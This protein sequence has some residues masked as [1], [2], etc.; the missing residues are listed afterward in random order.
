MTRRDAL[1]TL[2][3]AGSALLVN[4][5]T[6]AKGEDK[7]SLT[8][9]GI[10]T[11]AFGIHQKNQWNGRH[12]GLSPALAL[13]EESHRVGAA[14]IQVDLTVEDAPHVT[15]LRIRAERYGMY[16]EGGISP[17]KTADDLERF[18][19]SVL[20]AK[21]AGAKFART[22]ILPGRRYEQF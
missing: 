1:L 7:P 9:M 4:G 13:L 15:E 21:E 6:T 19:K 2:S 17:P 3:T 10:V 11:Y 20:L 18:E 14:G 12:K 22:V 8:K 5:A 16:V